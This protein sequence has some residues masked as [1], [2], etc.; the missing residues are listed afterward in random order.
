MEGSAIQKPQTLRPGL[1]KPLVIN[2]LV[3]LYELIGKLCASSCASAVL[4]SR[5]GRRIW[6]RGQVLLALATILVIMASA[7]FARGDANQGSGKGKAATRRKIPLCSGLPVEAT[8]ATLPAG[9]PSHSV[10]LSWKKSVPR[11]KKPKDRIKGYYIY[12]SQESH[13]F[14]DSNRLNSEPL[15]GTR[16]VDTD[17]KPRGTYFYSVKA[18]SVAGTPSDFSQ[19]VTVVI[20]FP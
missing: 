1:S 2:E 7:S 19:Q 6:G 13:D 5:G 14:S 12:R 17:V 18:V 8:A 10:T 15:A 11:S 20:P 9:A 4:L 3:G 16:C